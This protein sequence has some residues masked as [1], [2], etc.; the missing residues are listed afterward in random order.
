MS[1]LNW[2]PGSASTSK[3]VAST[4]SPNASIEMGQFVCGMEAMEGVEANP[5]IS[6]GRPGK[7][8][9][10]TLGSACGGI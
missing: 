10:E 1:R 5:D 7:V 4:G 3:V 9:A 2:S 8:R 6:W